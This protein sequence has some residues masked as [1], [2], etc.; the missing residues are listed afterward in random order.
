MI[1]LGH[2]GNEA[3]ATRLAKQ[4]L[5]DGTYNYDLLNAAWLLGTQNNDPDL[6]IE[7]IELR[8]KGWPDQE[9]DGLL[10]LGDLF[11][12]Q[13]KDDARALASY[14]AALKAAPH[15][16]RDAVRQRIPAAYLP[17]L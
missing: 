4:Y 12:V 13:K 16:L 8:N 1:L 5:K 7:A 9:I 10:K 17:R 2:V 14:R 6:A 15:N 3:E 11:A